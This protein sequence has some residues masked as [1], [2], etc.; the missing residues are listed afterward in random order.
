MP[1]PDRTWRTPDHRPPSHAQ[2]TT[3]RKNAKQDMKLRGGSD[4]LTKRYASWPATVAEVR[5][6]VRGA[7]Y[8][9][10]TDVR[11]NVSDDEKAAA[12]RP[13]KQK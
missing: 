1:E 9:S 5:T 12:A 4:E 6:M 10:E 2:H 8:V 7:S 11:L 3:N 13:L